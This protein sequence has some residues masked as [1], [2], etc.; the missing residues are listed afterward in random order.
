MSLDLEKVAP[1]IE[2]M[3]KKLSE[4]RTERAKHCAAAVAVLHKERDNAESLR[5]KIAGSHTP[6]LPVAGPVG[7]LDSHPG[8]NPLPPEF[9]VIASDGSHIDVDRHRQARCFLINVSAISLIYGAHPDAVIESFPRLYSGDEETVLKPPAGVSAR[10]QSLEGA[11]LGVKRGVDE[12]E[13]LAMLAEGLP[14]NSTALALSDGSLIMYGLGKE[15]P[16]F[17]INTFLQQG[18]IRHL[19]RMRKA[20]E[21]RQVAVAAYTSFP[22][23]GDVTNMLRIALCPH[24]FAECERFCSSVP[25]GERECD[26]VSGVSD[27]ELF[28]NLLGAGERSA[29]FASTNQIVR[30]HYGE[31]SVYFFYLKTDEIARIEV[32]KWVAENESL[33]ELAQSLILD[34]CRRGQGYPAALSEAHEEAVITGADR[35]NFWMLAESFLEQEN[36]P[37]AGSAKS[38]SKRMR[39]I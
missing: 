10:E 14:G 1:Q 19:D 13:M 20:N 39:W 38:F 35:E 18:Y 2:G 4:G 33:L 6:F 30:Q 17:V 37:T 9:T 3:A 24:D 7:T 26:I 8:A 22:R 5:R 27:R 31:H 21:T 23:S 36:I 12:F 34:Q 15:I 29:V 16:E 28:D 11:L 32:P 25:P